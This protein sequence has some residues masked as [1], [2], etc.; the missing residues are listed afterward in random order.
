MCINICIVEIEIFYY[1]L[2]S[3]AHNKYSLKTSIQFLLMCT[4][5]KYHNVRIFQN[6]N[7][8]P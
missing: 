5:C 1:L 3:I 2:N 8:H 4:Y 6:S 7:V